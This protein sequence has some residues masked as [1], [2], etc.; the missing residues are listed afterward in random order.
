LLGAVLL[1]HAMAVPL[2]KALSVATAGALVLLAAGLYLAF[3][4]REDS[5]GRASPPASGQ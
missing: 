1:M 2:L 5:G 4:L 3:S